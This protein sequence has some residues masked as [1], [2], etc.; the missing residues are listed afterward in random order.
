MIRKTADPRELI[1]YDHFDAY[2]KIYDS[3]KNK[4]WFSNHPIPVFQVPSW[5]DLRDLGK[6]LLYDGH[7][8]A[9]ASLESGFTEVPILVIETTMDVTRALKHD[10]FDL[11]ISTPLTSL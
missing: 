4:G 10:G 8:R 3:I 5:S 7:N 9:V 6:Y 2:P 11:I 1:L